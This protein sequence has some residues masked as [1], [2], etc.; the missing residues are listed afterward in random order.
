MNAY[1]KLQRHTAQATYQLGWLYAG[2]CGRVP[3]FQVLGR[4][5]HPLHVGQRAF[6]EGIDAMALQ[7]GDHR[8]GGADLS[9]TGR[10]VQRAV[11]TVVGIHAVFSAEVADRVDA[12]LRR[13]DQAHGLFQPEQP[14][15]GKELRRP[16]QRTTAV[17]P[18]R[19]G[20]AD[21]RL[22]DDHI[23]F[24]VLFLEHDGGPQAG[25]AATDDADVGLGILPQG[26]A[27][28]VGL[29]VQGLFQPERAHRASPERDREGRRAMG[30][31][32]HA[33]LQ[34]TVH[35]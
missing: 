22:D 34:C 33:S 3:A 6:A 26:R 17:A 30:T 13:F 32:C 24:G 9:M 27:G 29:I 12:L 11:E 16:G 35:K 7:R 23:E 4:A 31:L 1:A 5:R 10:G 20:A 19:A 2:R 8:V 14:L 15:Q 21:I 28:F 25:I 18:T